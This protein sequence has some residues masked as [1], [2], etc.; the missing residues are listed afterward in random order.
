MLSVQHRR[1]LNEYFT[2]IRKIFDIP[3]RPIGTDF[4]IRE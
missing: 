3:L 2:G 4:Q 1:Q